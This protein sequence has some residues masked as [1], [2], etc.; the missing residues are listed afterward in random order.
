M[1]F[2]GKFHMLWTPQY[3]G[4]VLSLCCDGLLCGAT[5]RLYAQIRSSWF[6]RSTIVSVTYQIVAYG[7]DN[8]FFFHLSREVDVQH[9]AQVSWFL[10]LDLVLWVL[11]FQLEWIF[12]HWSELVKG[13]FKVLCHMDILRLCHVLNVLRM[14]ITCQFLNYVL[15]WNLIVFELNCFNWS[16]VISTVGFFS[17][18]VK[19]ICFFFFF[20]ETINIF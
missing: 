4:F 16:S 20:V 18:I 5:E 9:S 1:I 11:M 17:S 6:F 13:H 2:C 19:E 12:L 14:C 10:L 7:P 3:L 15:C 8:C